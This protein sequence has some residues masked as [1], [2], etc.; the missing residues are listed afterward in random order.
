MATKKAES[1]ESGSE[2]VVAPSGEK[3]T[4]LAAS[5]TSGDPGQQLVEVTEDC[6]EELIY[7]NTT[8][9]GGRLIAPAGTIV[10]RRQAEEMGLKSG[11]YSD[12][13]PEEAS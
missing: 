11:Q 2:E 12:Y 13:K 3:I 10:T 7:P 4:V 1:A 9:S 6:E 8:R 5:G